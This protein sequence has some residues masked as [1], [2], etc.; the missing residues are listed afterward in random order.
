MTDS[1]EFGRRRPAANASAPAEQPRTEAA[2]EG[3]TGWADIIASP[4]IG[5]LAGVVGGVLIVAELIGLYVSGMKSMGR[6]LARSWDNKAI[7]QDRTNAEPDFLELSQRPCNI[8]SF[9]AEF[10]RVQKELGC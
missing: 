3:E 10:R 9:N 4:L 8:R 1:K 7:Q 5:Q 2:G 6:E